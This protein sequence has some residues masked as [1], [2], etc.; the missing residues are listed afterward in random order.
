VR[1]GCRRESDLAFGIPPRYKLARLSDFPA[2]RIDPIIARLEDPARAGGG[3]LLTGKPG[4]GKTHFGCAL[5]RH[6]R[7]L[8]KSAS[9]LESEH[10]FELS[11]NRYTNDTREVD[12]LHRCV[13]PYLLLVDD[14]GAGSLSDFERRSMLTLLNRRGNLLLPTIVTTNWTLAQLA[15]RYDERVASRLGEY[16]HVSFDSLPDKRQLR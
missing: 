9:F 15:V 7:E 5:V 3:I 8:G 14:I 16:W 10:F 6:F 12:I 2:D 11:R 4:R 1:C 13:E